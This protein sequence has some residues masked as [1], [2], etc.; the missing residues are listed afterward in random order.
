MVESNA[1]FIA[2]AGD[3]VYR[4]KDGKKGEIEEFFI[5]DIEIEHSVNQFKEPNPLLVVY[6][7]K[8]GDRYGSYDLFTSLDE[9]LERVK[10]NF[11][12][13]EEI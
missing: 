13:M 12:K 7:N 10:I 2:N 9:I 8:N 4:F 6:K 3:T 5:T 11:E 1:K